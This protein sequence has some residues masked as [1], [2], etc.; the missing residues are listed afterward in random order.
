V[1]FSGLAQGASSSKT[2]PFQTSSDDL[3]AKVNPSSEVRQRAK[4]SAILLRRGK[5]SI[6]LK[7][8]FNRHAHEK[9]G[10]RVRSHPFKVLTGSILLR[11]V[12]I[13]FCLPVPEGRKTI[14]INH[15]LFGSASTFSGNVAD[16]GLEASLRNEELERGY[17]G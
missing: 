9:R 16:F 8:N 14:H 7:G 3:L 15:L 4:I 6:R 1:S 5:K 2:I 13:R 10:G 17:R 12:R 11:T